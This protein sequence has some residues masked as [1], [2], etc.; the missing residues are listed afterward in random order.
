MEPVN[1]SKVDHL[2]HKPAVETIGLILEKYDETE[3]MDTCASRRTTSICG[4]VS[5]R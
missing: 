5:I 2:E 4:S 1:G 3:T